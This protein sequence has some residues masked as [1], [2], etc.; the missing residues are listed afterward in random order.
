M[1]PLWGSIVGLLSKVMHVTLG[2]GFG[3]SLP[4]SLSL[5]V[6]LLSFWDTDKPFDKGMLASAE[7]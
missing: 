4:A 2:H 7:S 5:P 6:R 3:R 1:R